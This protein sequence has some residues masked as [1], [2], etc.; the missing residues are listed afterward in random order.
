MFETSM[1]VI[2]MLW[3]RTA[4][5]MQH[6]YLAGHAGRCA[7]FTALIFLHFGRRHVSQNSMCSDAEQQTLLG[8]GPDLK[9]NTKKSD[10][11]GS[12]TTTSSD[13]DTA[14]ETEEDLWLAEDRKTKEAMAKR[15]KEEG[16]WF[17]YVKAYTVSRTRST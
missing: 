9:T 3:T 7:L 12:T 16:S 8:E 2:C 5:T 15:L 17:T 6:L 11:Y 1:L 10:G 4:T 13:S 14:A